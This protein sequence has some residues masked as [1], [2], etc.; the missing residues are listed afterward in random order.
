MKRRPP[1][2]LAPR[3]PGA[4]S[5]C[6]SP[7]SAIA[8]NATC[9]RSRAGSRARAARASSALPRGATNSTR[10]PAAASS[11]T[12]PAS[13]ATFPATRSMARTSVRRRTSAENATSPVANTAK[14]AASSRIA[15]RPSASSRCA[16]HT[17]QHPA[18]AAVHAAVEVEPVRRSS[19]R[20]ARVVPHE[21][22]VGPGDRQPRRGPV[23]TGRGQLDLRQAFLHGQPLH[24]RRPL[25]RG[26]V[27]PDAHRRT[28]RQRK[29]SFAAGSRIA[30]T[31]ADSSRAI[32]RWTPSMSSGR[33]TDADEP[34]GGSATNAAG[35]PARPSAARTST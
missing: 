3:E 22:G 4:S 17:A 9:P 8:W 35:F 29:A 27:D 14:S 1:P 18:V 20:G 28:A 12:R 26:D 16:I 30:R 25:G 5:A 13:C 15:S 11:A 24:Q 31:S 21:I 23:E 10:L 2:R 34:S 7:V 19:R 32:T 33:T 6:A